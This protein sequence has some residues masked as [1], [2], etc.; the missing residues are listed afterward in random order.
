M[1]TK[2]ISKLSKVTLVDGIYFGWLYKTEW[3][4]AYKITFLKN[5]GADH[6]LGL[7]IEIY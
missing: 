5:D 7:V 6:A 1:I 3:N 4:I 2:T